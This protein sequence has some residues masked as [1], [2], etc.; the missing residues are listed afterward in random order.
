MQMA[1]LDMPDWMSAVLHS[2]YDGLQARL[3][4]LGVSFEPKV[5][6]D[7]KKEMR[8]LD[9]ACGSGVITRE[10]A[11]S[12]T[13]VVG[14]DLSS[15]NVDRYNADMAAV[16]TAGAAPRAY[17]GDL[18]SGDVDPSL[19]GPEFFNFDLIVVGLAFH[20]FYDAEHAAKAL[21]DRLRPG[22]ELVAIEFRRHHGSD[23]AHHLPHGHG[24]GHNHHHRQPAQGHADEDGH[25]TSSP[26][27]YVR[28][29]D[30]EPTIKTHDLTGDT[31][32]SIFTGAGL[33][34]CA[35]A[36][37]DDTVKMHFG[38]GEQLVTPFVVRGRKPSS[39]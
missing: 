38:G 17:V 22:G 39:D 8:L 26:S 28:M 29:E 14:I 3:E 2:V 20:H 9:Y 4:R 15:A 24:H 27:V 35:W 33:K 5:S 31:V 18:V 21:T 16:H 10:L 23:Q 36:E 34:D 19:Q 30:V 25:G 1:S 11:S 32:V 7:G 13:S 6:G 37:Y 12:M